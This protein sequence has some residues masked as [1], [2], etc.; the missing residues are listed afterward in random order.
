MALFAQKTLQFVRAPDENVFIAPFNLIEIFLL[1]IPFE[2]WLR[3][4]RYE[5]LNNYVMGVVYSPLLLIT[6]YLETKQAHKV[7]HNRQVGEEDDDIVEEWEQMSAEVDFEGE[8]WA[9]KVESSRPNVETDAAVL[10]IRGALGK[11]EELRGQVEE[12]SVTLG[13][14][15]KEGSLDKKDGT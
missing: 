9:K 1:I 7:R 11:I 4:D 8:G 15:K 6:S 14:L 5:R 12:L 3:A 2:W 13:G 10:E